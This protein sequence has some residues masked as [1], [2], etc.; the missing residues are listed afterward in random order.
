MSLYDSAIRLPWYL[1]VWCQVRLK[2]WVIYQSPLTF[3]KCISPESE[4]PCEAR[5]LHDNDPRQLW[6]GAWPGDICG[7][8]RKLL[9]TGQIK[10][11]CRGLP[12]SPPPGLLLG[13]R[14]NSENLNFLLFN[15]ISLNSC[16]GLA[17]RQLSFFFFLGSPCKVFFSLSSIKLIPALSTPS[18]VQ[19]PIS[20]PAGGSGGRGGGS[21]PT[22]GQTV[23]THS[24]AW[25]TR[26]RAAKLFNIQDMKTRY[27]LQNRSLL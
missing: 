6:H 24:R 10:P 3:I 1:G 27:F 19:S 18:R 20:W 16:P 17:D 2:W 11:N 21:P 4:V 8:D 13:F 25:Y 12:S 14:L 26:Y 22:R 15:K 5:A 23:M 7:M 9:K